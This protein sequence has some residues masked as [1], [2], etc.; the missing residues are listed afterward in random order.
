MASPEE[1]NSNTK[2]VFGMTGTDDVLRVPNTE[3]IFLRGPLDVTGLVKAH[4]ASFVAIDA[5]KVQAR[6]LKR[7]ESCFFKSMMG[8][9]GSKGA[10]TRPSVIKSRV[11]RMFA[12]DHD[13]PSFTKGIF[14]PNSKFDARTQ[15]SLFDAAQN[16]ARR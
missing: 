1:D 11:G 6:G 10:R 14:N 8:G 12:A 2:G 15:G 13:K 4:S 5:S 16:H 9:F 7:V 3:H